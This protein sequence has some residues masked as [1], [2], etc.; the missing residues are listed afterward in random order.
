MKRLSE[1]SFT[2]VPWQKRLTHG[3][4]WDLLD[5]LELTDIVY[6]TFE[7]RRKTRGNVDLTAKELI[8]VIK[9]Y[10]HSHPKIKVVAQSP[11]QGK[12]FFTDKALK[13]R[14]V[15]IPGRGHAMDATRHMLQWLTFGA[16][17]RYVPQVRN[18]KFSIQKVVDYS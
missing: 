14:G 12:S 13:E 3:M 16:G 10:E 11:V 6:E 2:V 15:H 1:D 17:F 8:G 5:G 4:L 9:L 7:F 18:P